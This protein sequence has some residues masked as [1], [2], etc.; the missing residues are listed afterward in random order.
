MHCFSLGG[1]STAIPPA[2]AC[3]LWLE[4]MELFPESPDTIGSHSSDCTAYSLGQCTPIPENP[5]QVPNNNEP[6][7]VGNRIWSG[8]GYMS[9]ATS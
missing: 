2:I 1:F 9:C 8:I 6:L 7:P 3:V 4:L 5:L